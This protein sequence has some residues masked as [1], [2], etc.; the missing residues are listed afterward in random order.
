MNIFK[1]GV[2]IYT[3]KFYQDVLYLYVYFKELKDDFDK[4][5]KCENRRANRD[6]A[7]KKVA[8]ITN[9]YMS[10]IFEETMVYGGQE[11]IDNVVDEYVIDP[12][13]DK[14]VSLVDVATNKTRK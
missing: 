5:I 13:K 9:E 10:D 11:L 7:E 6:Y 3:C 14:V 12:I 4:M 8:R 2:S 1:C